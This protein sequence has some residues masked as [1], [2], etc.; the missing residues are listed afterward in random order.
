METID[1]DAERLRAALAYD[2]LSS[3]LLDVEPEAD[4]TRVREEIL[5]RLPSGRSSW[6]WRSR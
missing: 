6:P 5:V 3:Y 4:L 1:E 2:R